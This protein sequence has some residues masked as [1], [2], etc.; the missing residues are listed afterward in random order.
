[1]RRQVRAFLSVGILLALAGCAGAWHHG[2]GDENGTPVWL[3]PSATAEYSL[4]TAQEHCA[5]YGRAA[6]EKSREGNR[7]DFA[8]V[9]PASLRRIVQTTAM[10]SAALAELRSAP[11]IRVVH[12]PFPLLRQDP[13]RQRR[14]LVDW[15][16]RHMGSGHDDDWVG[17]L[18]GTVFDVVAMS[19]QVAEVS[20]FSE[21]LAASEKRGAQLIR[22]YTL[23]DPIMMVK[24]QL[25]LALRAAGLR[26]IRDVPEPVP[27]QTADGG[28]NENVREGMVIE[29]GTR[30]W[31]LHTNARTLDFLAYAQ[32]RRAGN[33]LPLW[34]AECRFPQQVL[35]ALAGERDERTALGAALKEK[36]DDLARECAAGL[37][38]SL[39]QGEGRT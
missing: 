25:L 18:L 12:Y 36:L 3:N 6:V 28:A 20:R 19:N 4:N 34:T 38:A 13:P 33:D 35:P 31:A 2:Q 21:G 16:M 26:E 1:M 10:D 5:R 11:Q 7:I 23:A 24:S 32:L 30:N 8:C 14:E 39:L 29:L 17:V 22:D 9:D 15:G 27:G 37:A